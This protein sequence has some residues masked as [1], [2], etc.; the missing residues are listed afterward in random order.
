MLLIFFTVIVS[1]AIYTNLQK[2]VYRA[3]AAVQWQ[4]SKILAQIFVETIMI[5][6]GDP[7]LSEEK[8]IKSQP[9]LEKAVI[10]L[11]LA[12]K[13][14]TPQE[15]NNFVSFLKGIVST[16]IIPNTNIIRIYVVHEQ[17]KIAAQIAN[18]VAEAYIQ[19]NLEDKLKDVRQVREFLEGRLSDLEIRLKS[20]EEALAN[21][22]EKEVPSGIAIP[23]QNRLADLEAKKSELL[24]RYTELHPEVKEIEEQILKVKEQLRQMPERELEYSRLTRE[25]EIYTNLYRMG[26]EKLELTR[27]TEAE[28][29]PMASLVDS[30]D[31]PASPISPN[32]QL[33]Y[34][35][36]TVIGLMLGL[37]GTFVVEQLDT[38]IGTIEDVENFIK[39]PVLGVI[40]YLKIKEEKPTLISGKEKISHLRNQLL[41]HYSI[42]SP[43]FEAYRILRTNIQTEVF[44]D[45]KEKN[46]C[47]VLLFSSA[48]PMEGK[49][50]TVANLAITMA[51]G[52]LRILLIDADMRRSAIHKIFGLKEKEPGLCD[53]LRGIAKP[54]QAIR[55]ITDL[56]IGEMGF[57]EA[58]KLPGL[59][60]LNILT[61][62]SLATTPAELLASAEMAPLLEK[63]REKFD[64]ILIDSPPVLAVADTSILAPKTDGTILVYRI[65]KTSRNV[66]NR[67]KAQIIESGALVKGIVLNN[68][69]PQV[70]MRYGYYY[71]YKYYGKYYG[72]KKEE[73]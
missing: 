7:M 46:K 47:K 57:D 1:S 71:H 22:K 58:L 29:V 5:K 28:K 65:G 42:S 20:S 4:V 55:T 10:D 56:L 9:V 19:L 12:G 54:E 14:A 39:L 49:S 45:F 2:P 6:P 17:P 73:T 67:A 30:A 72:E 61:G 24:R 40:P 60:Y 48:E 37:S 31:V 50:I 15:I 62:G 16:E 70:E 18:K 26:K 35:L 21:F 13:D 59:D 69:S 3:C 38:S 63:L 64:F 51:Q 25:V 52:N 27:I 43:I 32:K 53:I 23:L 34:L 8:I 36:G 11:G 66:L 33:N 44:K 68:I 41:I